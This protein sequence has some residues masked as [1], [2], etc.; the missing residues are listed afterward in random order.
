ML[1]RLFNLIFSWF[2]LANLFIAFFILTESLEDKSFHLPG[3]NV[4][5]SILTYAY[6]GFLIMCFLLAL[7]NRP[8]GLKSGY[9]MAFVGFAFLT[10]YMV[11]GGFSMLCLFRLISFHLYIGRDIFTGG[12]R[13]PRRSRH[14]AAE[15]EPSPRRL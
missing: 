12:Q 1:Y 8:Q 5:N 11:V 6:L 4:V 2:A 14:S 7:G 10:V 13:H 3:I 9:T 15:T